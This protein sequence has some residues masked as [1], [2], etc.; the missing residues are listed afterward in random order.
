MEVKFF[1]SKN[2]SSFYFYFSCNIQWVSSE[3]PLG[4][5]GSFAYKNI[6]IFI[7]CKSLMGKLYQI[8]A[9]AWLCLTEPYSSEAHPQGLYCTH[10]LCNII[11]LICLIT[12]SFY[13]TS[14][15]KCGIDLCKT[16]HD[17]KEMVGNKTIKYHELVEL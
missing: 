1:I 8:Q 13:F 6:L 10:S 3:Y 9:R 14:L 11:Q 4:V 2:P 17:S 12:L 5:M 15:I 7:S 16:R